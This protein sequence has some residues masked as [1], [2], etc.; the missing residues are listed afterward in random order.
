MTTVVLP[1]TMTAVLQKMTVAVPPKTMTAGPPKTMT[2]PSI[3]SLDSASPRTAML[4]LSGVQALACLLR[5]HSRTLI[6][7]LFATTV[8]MT[9]LALMTPCADSLVIQ[10]VLKITQMQSR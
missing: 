8:W 10:E 5:K 4:I 7:D 9:Q 1:I 2:T 6:G 3:R